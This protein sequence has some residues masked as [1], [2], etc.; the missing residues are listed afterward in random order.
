M[1]SGCSVA[2]FS[3]DPSQHIHFVG[4]GGVGLSA[5]A[6]VLLERG[7][8]ISGSDP[9]TNP[10]VEALRADGA[11]IYQGHAAQNVQGA[12]AVVR[13]SAVPVDNPEVRAARM[14]GIPVFRRAEFLPYVLAGRVS[15]AV[16]GTHGKTTTS[17]MIVHMLMAAG[18]EP[19]FIIGGV[20]PKLNT[21]ARAG[22]GPIFVIEAD[23]YDNMFLGTC[24]HVAVVTNIE[25]EH[26]DIFA[27]RGEVVA[28]F[29]RFVLLLPEDGLLVACAD[30]MGARALGNLW[31]AAGRK[32]LFYGLENKRAD[33]RATGLWNNDVGGSD[34]VVQECGRTRGSVRLQ[35]PGKHNV[36]NAL[37]ALAVANYFGLI[38][39]E[40]ED[41]LVEFT[42]A[43]RR[44][45]VCG[46]VS[47]VTAIDDYA[48][49]PT[50]IRAT[51]EAARARYPDKT[52]WAVWQP[53]TYSRTRAFLDGFAA[54]FDDADR[55][56]IT[57]VY[58][59]RESDTLGIGAEDVVA[60]MDKDRWVKHIGGD[61]SNVVDELERGV[62]G[63]DVVIVMSAGDATAI[64]PM[65]IERL[66]TRLRDEDEYNPFLATAY[67]YDDWD[68]PWA[69]AFDDEMLLIEEYGDVPREAVK[70]I[71]RLAREQK[72]S[73]TR[74]LIDRVMRRLRKSDE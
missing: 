68:D 55:V 37:A 50:A 30:D 32:V 40:A 64:G 54:S 31:R 6:R 15:V 47:G 3:L 27:D 42:G 29:A 14:Q 53:H 52:L 73:I 16:A 9:Q 11:R 44:F 58:A 28:A 12:H 8:T 61:L 56:I 39:D 26:P 57:D 74:G 38:F 71:R 19:G 43:G 48:H 60:R 20:L 25:H 23:E 4:I 10:L 41:A 1:E 21:N 62:S 66:E 5:I 35:V 63:N 2:G 49:H 13:S 33:L 72:V 46:R 24:P 67:E 70:E 45:S 51:L 18:L 22:E 36:L 17:S 7:F 65:L 69:D 59:A 34:F